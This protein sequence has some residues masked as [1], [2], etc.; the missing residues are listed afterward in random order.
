MVG[1]GWLGW[2]LYIEDFSHRY[3]GKAGETIPYNRQ[4]KSKCKT[5][6]TSGLAPLNLY[7]SGLINF[8]DFE[9]NVKWDK[10]KK[11]LYV[12]N[13]LEEEPY[14]YQGRCLRWFGLGY[15]PKD[16]GKIEPQKKL[17]R[18]FYRWFVRQ[19]YQVPS[20]LDTPEGQKDLKSEEDIFRELGAHYFTPLMGNIEFLANQDFMDDVIRFFE[21]IPPDGILYIHCLHGKGRTTTFLVLYDIFRNGKQLKLEEITIRQ[22]CFGRED[23]LDTV[24][25]ER[26]TWSQDGLNARKDLVERFYEYMNS[27]DGYP[28]QK[29]SQWF[30]SRG[31]V[32]PSHISIHR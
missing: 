3:Y 13:L 18:T 28:H 17:K 27:P 9:K 14:Y 25:W 10:S 31:Y 20:N 26:G 24:V 2:N 4:H 30:K 12:M 19:A 32:V 5:I 16:L 15:T 21:Q 1:C 8:N 11:N 23:V 7:A 22:H 6:N 29:W